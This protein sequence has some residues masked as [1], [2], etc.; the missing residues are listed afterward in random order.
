MKK[1]QIDGNNT[2]KSYTMIQ[3]YFKNWREKRRLPPKN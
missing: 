3:K 1:Y 2:F